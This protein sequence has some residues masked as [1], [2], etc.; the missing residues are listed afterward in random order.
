MQCC[1]SVTGC[2]ASLPA[3]SSSRSAVHAALAAPR[4]RCGMRRDVARSF[5]AAADFGSAGQGVDLSIIGQVVSTSILALGAW[6]LL[7]DSSAGGPEVRVLGLPQS[8]HASKCTGRWPRGRVRGERVAHANTVHASM[9]G[10]RQPHA[11]P[12]NTHTQ[13]QPRPLA[14][15]PTSPKQEGGSEPCP[16]CQGSGYEECMCRR[17]SDGD[18]GCSTCSKT[19]YMAC[20]SCRGGGTAVPILATQR[21]HNGRGD[22]RT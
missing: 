21:K 5:A 16:Q 10:L 17:W 4:R 13:N 12:C 9:H 22:T 15:A 20:R 1:S 14:P 6:T 19:G 7:S 11:R 3:A 8:T 18:V 2:S